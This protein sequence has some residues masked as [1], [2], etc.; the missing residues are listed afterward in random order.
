MKLIFF[1]LTFSLVVSGQ[2]QDNNLTI[3]LD[4]YFNALTSIKNFNGNVIIAKKGNVL[5]DKSYNIKD[6]SNNIVVDKDSKF[7][8]AS[9][10]KIF[11]KFAILKLVEQNKLQLTDKLNRFISDF[12][13]GDKIT[14]EHL[15]QH[16]SGLPRELKEYEEYDSLSLNQIVDLAKA[17]NL[18]FEPGTR[19]FYSNVGYFILHYII[20][21]ASDYGYLNFVQKEIF[22]KMNLKN[23]FEFNSSNKINNFAYGY[24]LDNEIIRPVK[25]KDIN[26]F[27]TG[28]YATTIND[29][30]SFSEQILSGKA[31]NKSLALKMF[32]GDSLITQAGGR[33]G[34][35][36]YFYKNIKSDITFIFTS[37]FSNVPFQ[38]VIDNVFSILSGKPF[39]IPRKVERIETY[40]AADVL[41]SYVGKFAL[42]VDP[43]QQFIIRTNENKLIFEDLEG[44]SVTLYP[45]SESV[46][47]DN[48]KSK[49]SYIFIYNSESNKYDLTI[50]TSG[51]QLKTK[52]IE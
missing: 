30:Y 51:M 15:M 31:L 48:P 18:Q 26:R 1:L 40:V 8:I 6:T 42:E 5:L 4:E 28:N 37:N 24:Y 25:L 20:Q 14:V 50:H 33:P 29:L 45:E 12:P 41:K 27:E 43:K 39:Q 16:R 19:I 10:S 44:N 52:R 34:Y 35:R 17:E 21:K 23:T 7:I 11:I 2:V 3:K 47:F 9:V 36:A 46:F 22:N 49:D 32:D 38:E 13:N